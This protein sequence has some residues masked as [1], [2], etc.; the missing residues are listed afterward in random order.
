MMKEFRTNMDISDDDEDIDEDGD[1]TQ[2]NTTNDKS[3]S[4]DHASSPVRVYCYISLSVKV[5]MIDDIGV[6]ITNSVMLTRPEHSRPQS[7]GQGH[8]G[9]E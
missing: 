8:P 6:I 1:L 4:P 7:Q 3:P 9:W 5:V 2:L